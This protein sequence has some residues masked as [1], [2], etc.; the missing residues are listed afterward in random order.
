MDNPKKYVLLQIPAADWER[1][2]IGYWSKPTTVGFLSALRSLSKSYRGTISIQLA[3]LDR[4]KW[5]K[6]MD[7]S[8]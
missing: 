5:L 6:S 1:Q 3:I 4:K 7:F 2:R 8:S